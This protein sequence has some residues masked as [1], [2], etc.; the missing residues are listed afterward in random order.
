MT[1][2]SFRW[3]RRK[4][5]AF[6]PSLNERRGLK[7]RM[8]L[9]WKLL[10]A[11]LLFGVFSYAGGQTAPP[12]PK[13]G[14]ETAKKDA[15]ETAKPKGDMVFDKDI[16]PLLKTY[17]IG[18][19]GGERPR[20]R[21][22]L[23]KYKDDQSLAKNHELGER[24]LKALRAGDMPPKTKP[25]PT[26]QE[27]ELLK[28]WLEDKILKVD[29]GLVQD[30]G[31][32]TIRRLNRNEY[33]NTI[34]DLLGVHF[35]PADDFPAD[36][37]GYGFDNI[38]DVL[39]LPPILLEKYMTAAEKIIANAFKSA[40]T[41][42]RIMIAQPTEKN[43][44]D[45]ARKIIENFTR[46]AYRRPVSA[47][48]VA[49]LVRFVE[50]ATANGDSFE[51]G[52]QL[53]LQ[54]VLVSPNFLFRIERDHAPAGTEGTRPI[55]EF[56]L[57]SRLSYFLWSTMPDEEL[58]KQ[59]QNE[60]L[61]KNLEPQIRRMLRDPKSKALVE[62]FAGQW[63]QL[64]ALKTVA[65]D[66]VMFPTFNDALRSAM[67]KETELFFESIMREDRS[68]LD[69]LTADYTFVNERLAKHYGIPGVKG[70]QFQRVRLTGNQRAGI[71][72][73]ASIL[74]VTSNPTRTSPVKRGKWIMENILGTPP[75]NPPAN[76]PELSEAKEVV[77]SAPLR[78]RM[79]QHRADPNCAVCHQHMD[80][81]GFSFENFNAIGAWRTMDGKFSI[82]PSGTLPNGQAFKGAKELTTLLK[83][84]K[85]LFARCLA[86][87][88]LTFALGR[89]LEYSDKCAVDQI[90]A[91]VAKNDYRFSSLAMEIVKSDPFE[92][93]RLSGE[94]RRP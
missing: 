94:K 65:P 73:Q 62:N 64:R 58:F 13:G 76:V 60:T 71:L 66:P 21:V 88:L 23:D 78:K 26:T 5:A 70:E 24:L 35:Q 9:L 6:L 77:E 34:R 52:I 90:V 3:P 87:K 28:R 57:A 10:P 15:K 80:T 63:L 53:T 37:I 67:Q 27:M 11:V 86:E 31:R 36:D 22:G 7:R 48:E 8:K 81:L 82:D 61:R 59:A 68:I 47:D 44:A 85:D 50:L 83:R 38:G 16:Q 51:R 29:C 72:T 91:A 93:R 39:S 32:V 55:A 42:Q 43:Q 79:E 25:K 20:G 49:R 12:G 33:N 14:K 41:R 1:C 74:T 2:L 92:M 46:R 19:H 45:A 40:D 75:P 56:E 54:A 4:P 84:D 17:C 30:P 18:C 69:F 89:G